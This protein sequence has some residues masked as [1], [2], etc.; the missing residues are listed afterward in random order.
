[1]SALKR[2]LRAGE[3]LRG[4]LLRL[5]SEFLVELA[6]V[7]GFDF[8]VIDCEHG[9]ADLVALQ[10]H[11]QAADA[12]GLPVL[13]RVGERDP[14]LVLRVLDLGAQGIVMPHVD[15]AEDAR[16]AVRAAHYPPNGER[17]FATYTRAGRFGATTIAE[18]L[19]ASAETTLIVGMLE[20]REA[21]AAAGDIAAVPG[22]DAVLVGPADLSVSMGLTGGPADPAVREVIDEAVAAALGAG[23]QVMSIVGGVEQAAAAPPGPVLYNLAHV[24][25]GTFRSLADR[26][27]R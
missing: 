24:L 21:C 15:S 16:W 18:H 6:G 10:Q 27:A 20:T 25:L 5:P 13:V 1:M 7:A 9:P 3:R 8:V 12:R 22:I 11:L 17:G 23:S 4:G 2:R 26:P 14:G 19:A